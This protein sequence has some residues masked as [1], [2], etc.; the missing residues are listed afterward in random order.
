[1]REHGIEVIFFDKRINFETSS[2]NGSVSWFATA[3]FTWKFNIG[4]ELNF[5]RLDRTS[6]NQRKLTIQFTIHKASNSVTTI[7]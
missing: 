5:V 4:K 1:M 2:G 6:P 3:W 7:H